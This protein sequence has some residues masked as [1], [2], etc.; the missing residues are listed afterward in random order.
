MIP[1]CNYYKDALDDILKDQS[2]FGLTVKEIQDALLSKI[3]SDDTIGKCLLE[4]R[5]LRVP[6][7]KKKNSWNQNRYVL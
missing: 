5:N 6:N 3:E 4:A 1:E 2:I 7:R